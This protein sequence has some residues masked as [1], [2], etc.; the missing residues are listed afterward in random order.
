MNGALAIAGKDLRE[1]LR[2]GWLLA[3]GV[4]M[5]LLTLAS[6][7]S[8]AVNRGETSRAL[9]TAEA[10]EAQTWLDQGPRNPHAAAHFSRYAVRP[11]SALDDV[12]P[13]LRAFLGGHVWMEAHL[14]RPAEARPAEDRVDPS[15][16]GALTPAWAF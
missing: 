11:L 6:A 4:V 3:A 7:L 13:G 12:D 16:L 1:S 9:A 15:P 2:A 8:A 10:Q 5:I 14:Q